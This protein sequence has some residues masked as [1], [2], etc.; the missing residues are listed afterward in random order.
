MA[1]GLHLQAYQDLK[2]PGRVYRELSQAERVRSLA[3]ESI[4]SFIVVETSSITFFPSAGS[5]IPGMLDYA[6]AMNRRLFCRNMWF[7]IISLNS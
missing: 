5:I 3:G 1:D 4:S 6:V 7:P 2:D